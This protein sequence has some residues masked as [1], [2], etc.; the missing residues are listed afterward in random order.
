MLRENIGLRIISV[1]LALLIWLQSVLVA[2]Q[3][4]VLNLPINLRFVPQNVT[5]ENIPERIPFSV[6]GK[7]QDILKM[8]LFKPSVNIDASKIRPNTDILSLDDYSIDLPENVNVTFLGPASSDNIA[9]QADVFHQRVVPVILDFADDVSRS[10]MG[11]LRYSLDPDKVT[12]FGPKNRIKTITGI[13][14]EAIGSAELAE[15]QSKLSIIL[16]QDD[17]SV[18]ES[19]VLLTISGAQEATKVFS[20]VLLPPGYLPSRVAVKVQAER[21][22]LDETS[23]LMIKAGISAEPDADGLYSVEIDLPEGLQLIAITPD[24]VRSR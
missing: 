11:D 23:V 13:K 2:E 3:K 5:L 7:G 1:L 10:R 14:T 20:N 19:S 4:S 9:I 12:I 18:S 22:V 21:A 24:K 6:K 8:W 17:I 16:P 15:S